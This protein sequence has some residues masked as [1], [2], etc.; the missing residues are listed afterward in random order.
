MGRTGGVGMIIADLFIP[1]PSP[2]IMAALGS[3]RNAARWVAGQAS[4]VSRRP[5]WATCCAMIGPSGARGLP[6]PSRSNAVGV[7]SPVRGVGHRVVAVDACGARS[8]R[9]SGGMR[10]HAAVAF[11]TGNLI[12]VGRW[13]CLRL[14]VAS[15]AENP[16]AALA[17]AF[18]LPY[19]G[20]PLF[21]I[22]FA[23]ERNEALFSL[24]RE[25]PV[26]VSARDDA[27]RRPQ[28]L[29]A[30][31]QLAK[32]V[33]DVE[34]HGGFRKIEFPRDHLVRIARCNSRSTSSSRV[35]AAVSG[36]V[37]QWLRVEGSQ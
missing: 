35:L 27:P 2:A 6:A 30:H 34:F 3:L 12:A 7:F 8:A 31:L 29:A 23:R 17:L 18:L 32:N 26:S 1:L 14:V 20:L 16:H 28:R 9:V 24:T 5:R 13:L 19:L 36:G 37:L 22:F 4:E 11:A 33:L 25:S 15:G 10:P 21:F